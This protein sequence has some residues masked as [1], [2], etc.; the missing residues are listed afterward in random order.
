[1][2]LRINTLFNIRHIP[3]SASH[4][5]ASFYEYSV[6]SIRKC[7]HL[8][9]FPNVNSKN[10]YEMLMPITHPEAEKNYPNFNWKNIWINICFKFINIYDR[11]VAFKFLHEILPNKKIELSVYNV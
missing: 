4:V 10:V 3:R 7:F 11:Q 8:K 5:N 2:A 6:D 1:M 9:G